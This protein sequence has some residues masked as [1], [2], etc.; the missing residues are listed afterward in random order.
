M[1]LSLKQYRN[2]D[3]GIMFF[4]LAAVEAVTATAARVWFPYEAYVL[5]PTV[6]MVCIVMMRWGGWAAVQAVGGGLALC[7]ASGASLKQF[8]VYCV[9]NCLALAAMALFR[10]F[11]KEK[12]RSSAG[13][14]LTF[15]VTAYAAAQIGRWLIGLTLGGSAGDIVK[16]LT[17]DSLSLI[18]AVVTLQLA[19]RLDGLF[20][21]QVAYIR[22]TQAQARREQFSDDGDLGYGETLGGYEI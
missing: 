16:L 17:T 8:A 14:T 10:V 15:T 6:A 2:I 21:D 19:R 18:F 3:L 5:S 4:I 22:R 9:G 13:L 20:E 11:G 1:S 7:I 12:I